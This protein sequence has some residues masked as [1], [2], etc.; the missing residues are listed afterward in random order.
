VPVSGKNHAVDRS[1]GAMKDFDATEIAYVP[2][3]GVRQVRETP[4]V[5]ATDE[6]LKGYG[7][8]VDEPRAFRSRSSV[9]RRKAGERSTRI[10]AI[11]VAS[12]RE[13]SSSAGKAKRSTPATTPLA[14][15]TSSPGATGRKK[16]PPTAWQNRGDKR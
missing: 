11:K 5:A 14:T 4:L 7:C 16:R 13:F 10:R 8:L 9:G 1:E 3:T 15:A 6:N 12:P 2:T